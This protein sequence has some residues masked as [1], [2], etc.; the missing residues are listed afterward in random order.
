MALVDRV[1]IEISALDHGLLLKYTAPAEKAKSYKVTHYHFMQ[2]S[3][4]GNTCDEIEEGIILKDNAS[5]EDPQG[6]RVTLERDRYCVKMYGK[7]AVD[8]LRSLLHL[9]GVDAIKTEKLVK[10]AD[11]FYDLEEQEWVVEIPKSFHYHKWYTEISSMRQ[12]ARSKG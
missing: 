9:P 6:E 12:A 1:E 5:P 2:S 11:N 3:R 8:Q 10:V 7:H 4:Y